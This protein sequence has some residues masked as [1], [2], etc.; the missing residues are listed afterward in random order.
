MY[1][2]FLGP[3]Q[4]G[5]D[6]RDEGISGIRR[7]LD[8]VWG[9]VGGAAGQRGS[10]AAGQTGAVRKLHQTIRKVGEDLEALQYHTAISAMMEYVNVL[11]KDGRDGQDGRDG[12]EMLEPLVVMLAPLA[13]HF[14]E[15]CWERLGHQES[16]FR[17]RW[18]EFDPEMAKAPEVEIVVQVNGKVR[19]RIKAPAGLLEAEAV[20]RA[21]AEPAVAKFLNG[22]EIRKVIY[23][24]DRLVN[25][26]VSR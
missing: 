25:L 13:P 14:A 20:T 9:L 8:K 10:G 3:Y 7:F 21:K 12:R 24:Q 23:V 5:G 1:L 26:V 11:R 16:V 18:P 15:E 17:A 19:G 22:N 6:F 4:E 2:M